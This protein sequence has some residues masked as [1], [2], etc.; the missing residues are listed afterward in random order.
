MSPRKV[1]GTAHAVQQELDRMSEENMLRHVTRVQRA[2][3]ALDRLRA[4]AERCT[5]PV[6]APA[7]EE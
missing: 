6:T 1:N 3:V 4:V 7:D 5:V 2:D